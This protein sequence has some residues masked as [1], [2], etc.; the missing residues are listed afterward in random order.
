MRRNLANLE[1]NKAPALNLVI[2]NGNGGAG[3]PQ[4]NRATGAG[5]GNNGGSNTN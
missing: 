3:G 2:R 4:V 5:A 1:G